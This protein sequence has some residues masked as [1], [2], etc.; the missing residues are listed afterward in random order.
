MPRDIAPLTNTLDKTTPGNQNDIYTLL[1]AWNK[2]IK[3]VLE[4]GGGSRFRDVMT[5]Y[6]PQVI[7]RVDAAATNERID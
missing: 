7:E 3:A 1:A 2:S 5:Q 4:R 6:L